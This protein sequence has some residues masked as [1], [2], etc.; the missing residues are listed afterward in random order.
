L[1]E[2]FQDSGLASCAI[3]AAVN[4]NPLATTQ[5]NRSGLTKTRAE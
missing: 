2:V 4:K 3:Q 1:F 5:M